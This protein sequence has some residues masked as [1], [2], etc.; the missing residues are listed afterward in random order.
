MIKDKDIKKYLMSIP[1]LP[2][3]LKQSIK[4]LDDGDLP[5]AA[6]FAANDPALSHYLRD[7]ISKPYFGFTHDVKDMHQIFGAMG[8][9]LARQLLSTY[10][11]NLISPQKW[12]VFDFDTA[13]F[14]KLQIE[15]IRTWEKILE[16]MRIDNADV[17]MSAVLLPATVIVCEKLFAERKRDV[18]LLRE[19]KNL[20]FNE[21][22]K[23]LADMG[24]YDLAML[25]GKRWEMPG[26][27][28]KLVLLA[29]GESSLKKV[30]EKELHVAKMLHMTFFYI[31]SR[32]VYMKAGLNE[33][34][35]LNTDFIESIM[36]SFN[37]MVELPE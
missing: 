36:D 14:Q 4:A 37:D 34:V 11:L 12:Y 22:L 17:A 9:V 31:L 10:M 25:I 3:T 32:P 13:R 2:D 5:R 18:T 28:M 29:S 21:I 7:L 8:L 26:V 6:K 20:S 23:R 33:F 16:K 19:T 1:P 24:F 35:D 27:T 30:S 15:C